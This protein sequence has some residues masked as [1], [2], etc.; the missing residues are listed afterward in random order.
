[1]NVFVDVN[2]VMYAAGGPHPHKEPSMRFLR[3]AALGELEAVS[4]TEVLQELLYR[5][6]HVKIIEQ[7]VALVEHVVQVVPII[8]PVAKADVLLARTLLTQHRALEP[9]DAIHA[10]VM[11]NHGITQLYSY[12][13]HFDSIPGLRRLEP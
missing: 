3:R 2:V 11:F 6:W 4:D 8:L 1:M 10:A 5:Y 13:R 9:R 12:D 7:G